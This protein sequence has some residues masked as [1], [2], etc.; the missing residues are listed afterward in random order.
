MLFRKISE[1]RRE[2]R[3]TRLDRVL[4]RAVDTGTLSP[5]DAEGKRQKAESLGLVGILALIMEIIQMI[6][7]VLS[8]ENATPE[9]VYAA[10]ADLHDE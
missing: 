10:T 9:E 3:L 8:R 2:R 6:I 7:D 4:L 1:R 5:N